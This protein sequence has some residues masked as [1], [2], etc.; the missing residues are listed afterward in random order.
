MKY[1]S[2]TYIKTLRVK[3]S[4][5]QG[6]LCPSARETLLIP[7][8]TVSWVSYRYAETHLPRYREERYGEYEEGSKVHEI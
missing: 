5:L 4:I 7:D 2:V 3:N 1:A 6:K 8:S